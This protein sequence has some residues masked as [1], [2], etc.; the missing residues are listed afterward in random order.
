MSDPAADAPFDSPVTLDGRPLTIDE[1]ESVARGHRPVELAEASRRAMDRARAIVEAA[2]VGPDAVYGVNTG[3][4]SLSRQRIDA[5]AIADVQINIVRSH[6]AGVGAPLPKDLVR[7]M[8]VLLAAS[9]ARGRSGARP[10]VVDG[11]LAMLAADITPVVP[12][13][14]SVG[15]SG[16]LAPLSH[17]ALALIGEGPVTHAADPNPMPAADAMRACGI[18]PVALGAKEGLALLNGTHLMAAMGALAVADAERLIDASIGAAAMAVDA[19]RAS[20]GPF[21]ARIHAARTQPGQQRVAS[22]LRTMLAGSAILESHRVDDP[23]VQDPYCLRCIPQVIGA[24]VDAVASVRTV[25]DRELGAVT[26]NPLVFLDDDAANAPVSGDIV[27]GG[28]F[29]GM[30]LA[31]ALDHLSIALCHLAGISERRTYW[32]LAAADPQ[33]PLPPHLSPVPGLHSGLMITQ[34]TAAACVN[35]LQV[36][37]APAS[38]GNI[39][40][41]AGIEDYNSFGP[42]AGH[43]ARQAIERVRTVIAIEMLVMSEGLDGQRPERS[44]AHVEDLHTRI[45]THVPRLVADRPPSPDIAVLEAHIATG[46]L[47]SGAWSAAEA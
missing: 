25:I 14:G 20:A 42:T 8:M 44:G 24:V 2:A 33:N 46:G 11:L 26:D 13:V 22:A 10:L 47:A 45:R 17:V 40:T 3:F 7:A 27:S 12:G 4:G 30:P 15:A 31:I 34:Y 23:R 28:N 19:S 21:D 6:A 37:A 35:E 32:L 18:S 39:P 16:D 36:L 9:L 41:S 29:H 5:D 1:I 43:Q 38:V